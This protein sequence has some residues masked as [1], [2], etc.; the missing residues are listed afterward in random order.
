MSRSLLYRIILVAGVLA[1]AL[2]SLV[3]TVYYDFDQ[4]E[5]RLPDWWKK[6]NVLPVNSLV[7]GLDLQ[8]G[9]DL[10]VSVNAQE[11][12]VAELRHY[13]EVIE[14]YF[15]AEEIATS[16]IKV[17]PVG[18]RINLEFAEGESM[19][20][21]TEWIN[22]YYQVEL[23][24]AEGKDTI[25][26]SYK[27]RESAE[28]KLLRRTVDQ[29][30]EIQARRMDA[31]GLREPEIVVQGENH[32]RLQLPGVRDSSRI[33]KLVT[34]TAKLD[35]M[36]VDKIGLMRAP[37]EAQSGGPPA[38]TVLASWTDPNRPQRVIECYF[39]EVSG[40][41][42]G[43]VP[44]SKRLVPHDAARAI[45]E[46]KDAC[47]LLLEMPTVSGA[48]LKDARPGY[49]SSDRLSNYSVVNF[50]FNLQGA[51]QF[52]KLTGDNIGQKLA[53]V[54]EDH[55][56]SAP[57]IKDKIFNRGVISGR[58]TAEDAT[59]LANVLRSGALSVNINIEEE[60]TVGASLGADSIHKGQVAIFWGAV[61]VVVFMIIYYRGAGLIADT[62]LVMNLVLIMAALSIF[63]ATL[64]LPGLAGIVL[65][66]GMAVDANVLIFERVREEMRT[67]KTPAASIDAG[68]AKALWTIL[69]ANITTLIA[70]LVLLQWGTGPIKGFAVTLTLGVLSSMFTAIVV[71]RVVYDLIFFLRKG[72]R[73]SIGIKL[74]PIVGAGRNGRA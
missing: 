72:A 37:A 8:G 66:V 63:G 18:K 19:T 23:V 43:P 39:P 71:T 26:P 64:T 9:M 46:E 4:N 57:V 25:H 3:P 2:L 24:V 51:R 52:A 59:I 53:I 41:T 50:E 6:T 28:K 35:F 12:V 70:A 40:I 31:Y 36:L 17:D 27:M 14:D 10:V 73:I 47:Y 74:E 34:S 33:K 58:F 5:S 38:G 13:E 15:E 29:I 44:A 68:Y 45:E 56:A 20:K 49:D 7:L 32:I 69:D 22:R 61:V 55:V 1:I 54:L 11:A 65:T 60:R 21:G 16:L 62:A 67:G 48:D 42:E 30:K